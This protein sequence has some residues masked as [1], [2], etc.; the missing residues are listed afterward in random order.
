[1]GPF[2]Q[3]THFESKMRNYLL[4]QFVGDACDPRTVEMM[5]RALDAGQ[6]NTGPRA[7]TFT[8]NLHD[9][10]FDLDK[11]YVLIE[12]VTDVSEA[13]EHRMTIAEF[14][15]FLAQYAR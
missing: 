3:L 12:D 14:R 1:M 2:V 10:T 7:Q 8:F 4:E 11:D 15:A 6:A 5:T 13:G 9:V